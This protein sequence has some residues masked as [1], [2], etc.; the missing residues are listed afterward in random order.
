M[1]R[2]KDE[3]AAFKPDEAHAYIGKKKISRKAFYQAIHRG[4]IPSVRLGR[5]I[6]IPKA[7]FFRWL[8]GGQQQEATTA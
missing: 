4:E 2:K 1:P 8:E 6:L 5:R 3:A 7:A